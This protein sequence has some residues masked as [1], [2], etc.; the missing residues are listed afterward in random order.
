MLYESKVSLPLI[1][2]HHRRC[3]RNSAAHWA[4]GGHCHL[5]LSFPNHVVIRCSVAQLCLFATPWTA[6][7]QASLSFTLSPS[8]LKFTFIESVMPS[9]E[10]GI[11]MGRC[12]VRICGVVYGAQPVT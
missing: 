9:S 2:Y 4:L 11:I 5:C 12:C 7:R 8:L 1:K 3:S 6:A 10:M